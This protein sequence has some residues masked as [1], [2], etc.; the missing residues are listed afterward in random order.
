VNFV[1]RA[2]VESYLTLL[3]G[4]NAERITSTHEAPPLSTDIRANR[5]LD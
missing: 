1:F 5:A 2:R 3:R 4:T